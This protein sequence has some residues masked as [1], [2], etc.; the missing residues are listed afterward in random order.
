MKSKTTADLPSL[1]DLLAAGAHFGHR[2][3]WSKP[4][5]RKYTYVVRDG[6]SVINLEETQT[7]L[8][9]AGQIL[10][11]RVSRG[12]IV[13]FVGTKRQA[14]GTVATAAKKVSMPVVAERWLGGTLTNFDVIR[15]N[16]QRMVDM[17]QLLAN[18][19]EAAK[20]TKRERLHM[21]ETVNKLHKNLDGIAELVKLPDMLLVIDP[22]EEETAVREARR[23]HVPVMALCDTNVDPSLIDYAIPGND[24]APKTIELVLN[25]LTDAIARGQA[26]QAK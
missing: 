11:D 14:S 8:A 20:L 9:D 1:R 16:I 3:E 24:D 22:S 2:K 12:A 6:V 25:Y 21:K 17:E 10:E 4:A 5:A 23:M 26:K 15:G 19:K 13:L 18:D 7:K